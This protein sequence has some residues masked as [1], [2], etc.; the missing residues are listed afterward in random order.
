M[1]QKI[2]C[3][4]DARPAGNI[5][6]AHRWRFPQPQDLDKGLPRAGLRLRCM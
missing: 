3:R 6:T 5:D 2:A 1:T 4:I